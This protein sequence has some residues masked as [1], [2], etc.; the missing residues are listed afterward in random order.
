MMMPFPMKTNASVLVVA[1]FTLLL[2]TLLF[3]EAVV[4]AA[5]A[6][7]TTQP[8]PHVPTPPPSV[9]TINV[10]PFTE[11]AATGEDSTCPA[12]SQC[13]KHVPTPPG[14]CTPPN[15]KANLKPA[16]IRNH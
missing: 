5:D 10:H 16:L 2:T 9:K 13:D 7:P 4:L 11:A 6:P 3:K 15:M 12:K 14:C 8:S 1:A